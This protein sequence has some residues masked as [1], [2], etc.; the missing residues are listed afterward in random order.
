ME[1]VGFSPDIEVPLDVNLWQMAGRDNQ[2][3][4]AVDYIRFK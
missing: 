1:G 4:E 2:L 3:E